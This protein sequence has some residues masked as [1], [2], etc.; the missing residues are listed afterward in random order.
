MGCLCIFSKCDLGFKVVLAA[1]VCWLQSTSSAMQAE[2]SK[3]VSHQ[4]C[5]YMLYK[6]LPKTSMSFWTWRSEWPWESTSDANRSTIFAHYLYFSDLFYTA[7]STLMILIISYSVTHTNINQKLLQEAPSAT[8][9]VAY[10]FVCII[11][12]NSSTSKSPLEGTVAPRIKTC[13]PIQRN[14]TLYLY[15]LI[16][17]I[18]S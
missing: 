11:P 4:W 16:Y 3:C 6:S 1:L 7:P 5:I 15:L 13:W 9:I 10:D 8:V 12:L 2:Y 18:L 14:T 17:C